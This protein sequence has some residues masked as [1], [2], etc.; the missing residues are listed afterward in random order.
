MKECTLMTTTEVTT[1]CP[2]C[3]YK[4]DGWYENPRGEVTTCDDCGKEF[5]VNPEADIEYGL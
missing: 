4:N 1:E 3:N 5:K 2:C